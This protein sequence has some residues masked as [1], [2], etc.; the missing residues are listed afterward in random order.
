[1][2][3]IGPGVTEEDIE[4]HS[5][6]GSLRTFGELEVVGEVVVAI[7]GIVP[8][9]LADGVDAVVFQ[10]GFERFGLPVGVDVV[11]AFSFFD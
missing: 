10:D 6:T 4:V 11:F 9:T 7:G 1:M 2:R 8:E 5:Q 3:R